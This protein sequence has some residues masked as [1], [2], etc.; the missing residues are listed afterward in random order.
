M[1]KSKTNQTPVWNG[2]YVLSSPP[3][4][5]VKYHAASMKT[6]ARWIATL[7]NGSLFRGTAPYSEGPIVAALAA[8]VKAGFPHWVVVSVHYIDNSTYSIAFS[9]P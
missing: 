4:A 6:G 8:A 3:A 5:L 2:S 7:N 9:S 1:A